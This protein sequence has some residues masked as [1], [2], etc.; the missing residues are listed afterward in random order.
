MLRP[1]ASRQPSS[2]SAWR[3]P[4]GAAC[5]QRFCPARQKGSWM[6]AHNYES[7]FRKLPPSFT[8]PNPSVWP[9]STAYWFG[10]VDPANN[11]DPRKGVLTSFYENNQQVIVCP[12]LDP[13]T[14][15]QV[16]N[17]QSGGYGYN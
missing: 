1:R 16:Y 4:A 9:Y 12:A 2:L 5:R 8:T 15:K 6:A 7:Q 14:L 10:L 17:G 3:T 13:T 11:V